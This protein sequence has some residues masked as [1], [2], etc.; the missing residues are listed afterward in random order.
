MAGDRSG[1]GSG[2]A[3]IASNYV[4]SAVMTVPL[5]VG[6]DRLRTSD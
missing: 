4:Q 1:I 6:L 3:G 2:N 5:P